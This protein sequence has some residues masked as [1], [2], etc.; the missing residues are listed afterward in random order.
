MIY[1]DT[2]NNQI[3][4]LAPT[5]T[6][7]KLIPM[8]S[9]LNLEISLKA[10]GKTLRSTTESEDWQHKIESRKPLT[11]LMAKLTKS[12]PNLF[13]LV[14]GLIKQSRDNEFQRSVPINKV[15]KQLDQLLTLAH[16]HS[17]ID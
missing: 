12:N 1:T 8:A 4:I 17:L 10:L 2:Q 15:F 14:N 13:G 5:D 11:K 16:R 3:A 7:G 9:V 6:D